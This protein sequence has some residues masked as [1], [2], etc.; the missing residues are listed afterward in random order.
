MAM[1]SGSRRAL[2]DLVPATLATGAAG[3][4]VTLLVG[5]ATQ[6]LHGA[7]APGSGDLPTYAAEL[8]DLEPGA[9]AA[10]AAGRVTVRVRPSLPAALGVVSAFDLVP[11][12]GGLAFSAADVRGVRVERAART[13]AVAVAIAG[14]AAGSAPDV[15][16]SPVDVA[17]APRVA[18]PVV[19]ASDAKGM[20]RPPRAAKTS[21]FRD[22]EPALALALASGDRVALA[23]MADRDTSI[24]GGSDRERGRWHDAPPAHAPAHGHRRTR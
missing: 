7:L 13:V 11:S 6:D 12:A 14:A 23:S 4:V 19:D 9:P 22:V 15:A 3:L 21:K 5:G 16:A 17:P 2:R 8:A 1:Q 24:D 20:R 10:A 18:E